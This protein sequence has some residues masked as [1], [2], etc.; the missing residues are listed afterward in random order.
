MY[1][2]DL[3]LDSTHLHGAPSESYA[4]YQSYVPSQL[5]HTPSESYAPSR[6]T[7]CMRL[8]ICTKAKI[9]IRLRLTI[10]GLQ[11]PPCACYRDWDK[12][13]S[14]APPSQIKEV[15]PKL[16]AYSS[17]SVSFLLLKFLCFFVDV[18]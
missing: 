10:H 12:T 5:E 17:S 2:N 13:P 11:A 8:S 7:R 6:S 15:T 18:L 14:L 9:S 1:S 3:P 16:Y 4:L